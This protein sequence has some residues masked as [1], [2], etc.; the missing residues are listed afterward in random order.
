MYACV[1]SPM[2]V[3]A[4]NCQKSSIVY[5]DQVTAAFKVPY[6]SASV[7]HEVLTHSVN[8]VTMNQGGVQPWET[9]TQLATWSGHAHWP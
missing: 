6:P 2:H 7:M 9:M 4:E 1:G 5:Y 8:A 3:H